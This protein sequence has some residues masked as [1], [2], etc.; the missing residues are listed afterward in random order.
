MRCSSS[1][2][3]TL[4]LACLSLSFLSSSSSLA[5]CLRHS[6]MYSFSCSSKS[7]RFWSWRLMNSGSSPSDFA[8]GLV[9][10]IVWK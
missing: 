10:F 8:A 5:R 6:L 1:A 9:V 3:E 2:R 4:R 7:E